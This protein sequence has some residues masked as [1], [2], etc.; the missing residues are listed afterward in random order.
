TATAG[1]NKEGQAKAVQELGGYITNF[2]EFLATAVG[3][4]PAAV[5]D[6]VK[7]HVFQLKGALD[8]YAGNPGEG[9]ED[10]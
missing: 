5:Q 2:G 9:S 6:S 4:P 3:L 8:A 1:D 10:H 7:M